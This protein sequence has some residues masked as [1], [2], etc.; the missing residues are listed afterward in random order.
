MAFFTT[1]ILDSFNR[2]DENPIAGNWTSF[3][4]DNGLWSDARL[5][6]N[7]VRSSNINNQAAAYWNASTFGP[8]CEAFLTATV[9]STPAAQTGLF[10]RLTTPGPTTTDGYDVLTAT[11]AIFFQRLDNGVVTQLGANV[12]TTI[13]D[14]YKIG[15]QMS[16][17]IMT[18][19][20]DSG[21][22]WTS[23]ASRTDATYSGSG[24]IGFAVGSAGGTA[25]RI[26]DFGGGTTITTTTATGT[27]IK[28]QFDGLQNK[29]WF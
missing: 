8:D 18:F 23:V 25:R 1:S 19:Y 7:D 26:D 2:A 14:G 28:G 17:S 12:P 29:A 11:T 10:F 24:Y 13:S 27:G 6:S 4:A 3:A 9:E 5:L 15:V 21:S 22:G 16:G 20:V